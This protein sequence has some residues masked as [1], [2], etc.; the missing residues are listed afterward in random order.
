MAKLVLENSSQEP[1]GKGQSIDQTIV[2]CKQLIE[3]LVSSCPGLDEPLYWMGKVLHLCGNPNSAL[4]FLEKINHQS[5][6]Y[7]SSLLLGAKI[8]VSEGRHQEAEQ[9]LEIAL[10]KSFEVCGS[11]FLPIG[12]LI[13]LLDPV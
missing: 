7:L 5:P 4:S 2:K 3:L 9:K 10:G 11:K 8:L 6:V 12:N 13:S 1:V